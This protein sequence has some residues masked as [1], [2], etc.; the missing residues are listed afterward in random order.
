[1]FY[2]VARQCV[3]DHSTGSRIYKFYARAMVSAHSTLDMIAEKISETNTLTPADVKAV[4]ESLWREMRDR[5]LQGQIVELGALGHFRLTI[6]NNGGSLTESGWKYSMIKGPHILHIPTKSMKAILANIK[7]TRWHN[8]EMDSAQRSIAAATAVYEAAQ[9]QA[10]ISA[11]SLTRFLK[12]RHLTNEAETQIVRNHLEAEAA[13][14]QLQLT[15]AE[16]DLQNKQNALRQMKASILTLQGIDPKEIAIH[17]DRGDEVLEV[18][19]ND[20]DDLDDTTPP[21]TQGIVGADGTTAIPPSGESAPAAGG[22]V[23]VDENGV[24]LDLRPQDG[25]AYEFLTS[26]EL[27]DDLNDEEAQHLFQKLQERLAKQQG[28]ATGTSAQPVAQPA[29]KPKAKKSTGKK[30]K[31]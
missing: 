11:S 19:D 26:D 28:A 18:S 20:V 14:D 17:L 25:E 16:E 1:M 10:K 27:V 12:Q 23:P 29:A 2:R 30:K 5:L 15:K 8:P 6:R 13:A 21:A 4:V 31:K 24:P 7:L 9:K 22:H 3:F